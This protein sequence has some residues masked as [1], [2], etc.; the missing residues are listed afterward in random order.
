MCICTSN[1]AGGHTLPLQGTESCACL[2]L[3]KAARAVTQLFDSALKPAK[4]RSTQFSL[5]VVV[6]RLAPVPI[7]RLAQLLVIDR[8]TLTRS[9]YLMEKH[10]L[11]AISRRS[12]MRQKFVSLSPKGSKA[13]ENCLP[14]WREAQQSF[15]DQV[16]KQH[17]ESMRR[18]LA[19]LPNVAL[20]L[21]K[22]TQIGNL[23]SRP[24]G[25]WG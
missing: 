2:N 8:T 13:L 22:A 5:L 6:A 10:G 1:N 15:V 9:L 11:V 4:V 7:G 17:W 12:S 25:N 18:E 16:G 19:K 21:E 24:P 14:L 3:R 23:R 20:T